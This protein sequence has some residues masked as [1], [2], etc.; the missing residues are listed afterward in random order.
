MENNLGCYKD[1]TDCNLSGECCSHFDK[2]NFHIFNKA[3]LLII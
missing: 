1:S 2:I 3:E